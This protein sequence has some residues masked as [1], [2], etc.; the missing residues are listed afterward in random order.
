MSLHRSGLAN[1]SSHSE[2]TL[3]LTVLK[4]R[5]EIGQSLDCFLSGCKGCTAKTSG[6]IDDVLMMIDD[7]S[8]EAPSCAAKSNN[9]YNDHTDNV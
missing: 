7:L 4:W 5:R 9:R 6:Q 3:C 1:S 8:V 2:I